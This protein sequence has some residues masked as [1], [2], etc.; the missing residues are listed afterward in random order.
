MK[1]ATWRSVHRVASGLV[2]AVAALHCVVTF[3]I[4]DIGTV[5]ALW[6]FGTGLGLLLLGV[7]NWSHVGAGPCTRPTAPVLRYANVIY[8]A[9]AVAALFVIREPQALLLTL[10]LLLQA[11]AG[12]A[13]L[14]GPGVRCS[15]AKR[16][17]L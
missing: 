10:A 15:A 8:A 5:D 13:T 3:F 7:A 16:E 1:F 11:I 17:R 6:F 9:F 4:Y 2:G 12:F 14:K